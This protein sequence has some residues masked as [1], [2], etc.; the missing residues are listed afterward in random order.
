MYRKKVFVYAGQTNDARKPFVE[1]SVAFFMQGSSHMALLEKECSFPIL[2]SALPTL[3]HN[4][5]E[6]Y[7]FPLGGASIWVL[8]NSKTES[9]IAG[10]R[11]FL[12]YLASDQVQ[13]I[14]HKQ[15]A[16]VP[17][18]SELPGKLE[19]FYRDHPLHKAV[20]EQTIEAKLGE[21]SYGIHMPNYA[22][23][24]KELF[25]LIENVLDSTTDQEI[26]L[27]LKN[28]DARFNR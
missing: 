13:E 16:S 7:A 12:S 3:T 6:K 26:S 17:V 1:A 11:E 25:V 20:V 19:E 23:A 2:V 22:D 28:F 14:W 8:N 5:K 24:R 4:Q 21:F 10:V 15:T 27:L 18:S 9:M